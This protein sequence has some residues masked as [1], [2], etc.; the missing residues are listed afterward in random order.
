M[1]VCIVA[2]CCIPTLDASGQLIVEPGIV[3]ISD[4]ML[5]TDYESY[6]PR[7]RKG[8]QVGSGLWAWYAGH[9]GEAASAFQAIREVRHKC[10]GHFP[11]EFFAEKVADYRAERWS[12]IVDSA[13]ADH[14]RVDLVLAGIDTSGA[15]VY[16]ITNDGV[17]V[18]HDPYGFVA[19]GSG[20]YTAVSHLRRISIADTPELPHVILGVYEA[21]RR[22]ETTPTVGEALDLLVIHRGGVKQY[23]G[24]EEK[25]ATIYSAVVKAEQKVRD[26]AGASLA[27]LVQPH[28]LSHRPT[29]SSDSLQ[30]SARTAPASPAPE[31][32]E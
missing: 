14:L 8:A 28:A 20:D 23:Q 7:Q 9:P 29:G 6:E 4:R 26:R 12:R 22:A 16:H 27:T 3:G 11:I 30:T 10:Q 32:T 15:H 5:S 13:S 2:I 1:T 19:I 21:K 25:L 31:D 24:L 17:A 18:L